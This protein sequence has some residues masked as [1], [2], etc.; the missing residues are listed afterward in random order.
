M[1]VGTPAAGISFPRLALGALLVAGG[2]LLQSPQVLAGE[3]LAHL[4]LV[5]TAAIL[6]LHRLRDPS[7]AVGGNL[8]LGFVLAVA[9]AAAAFASPLAGA[10]GPALL[11]GA[12][13]LLV[14]SAVA[15][16]FG[17]RM[18]GQLAVPLLVLYLL[19]P[20]LPLF[21]A[22]L[23]YP[24]RRLSALLA[25]GLLSIGPGNVEL[26]GTELSWGDL[27]VSVTSACSGLTLLQNLL[28]VA[29]WTV[30]LR[31]RGFLSRFAH[32][33]LAVPAVVMANTLRVVALALA[34]R[35]F[36]EQILVGTAHVV[37]GWVAVA[38]AAGLF[39]AMEQAFPATAEARPQGG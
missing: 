21:E 19:V 34:A 36:G 26:A 15:A 30:L 27:R 5:G 4:I 14:L 35:W 1:S 23:S 16:V 22:A 37:I 25:A 18:F 13:L 32:G 3:P 31:H 11:H 6:V 2:L 17:A 33:L 38:L 7:A 12:L 24:M 39:L 29:W 28:W 9:G 10:L 20:M 8:W